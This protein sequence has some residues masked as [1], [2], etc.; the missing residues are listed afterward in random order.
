MKEGIQCCLLLSLVSHPLEMASVLAQ[1]LYQLQHTL[2]T[3]H[4]TVILDNI[5]QIEYFLER[6]GQFSRQSGLGKR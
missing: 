5:T 6:W 2:C 4:H 3:Y 1:S